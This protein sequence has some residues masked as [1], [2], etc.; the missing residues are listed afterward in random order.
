MG[1]TRT[2]GTNSKTKDNLG[3][4]FTY[5]LGNPQTSVR[6]YSSLY[7]PKYKV[8][9][10]ELHPDHPY[11]GGPFSVESVQTTFQDDGI[12][13]A[14]VFYYHPVLKRW[15]TGEG[16][17]YR[18]SVRAELSTYPTYTTQVGYAASLG[19]EAWNRM[20]P[21][22]KQGFGQTLIEL[23]ELTQ[24][25]FKRVL[26]L[27]NVVAAL[28][29][30]SSNYLAVEFGWKPL[31]RDLFAFEQSISQI[32][33]TLAQLRAKNGK[34]MRRSGTLF[35]ETT[36]SSAS[37][38]LG[39]NPCG[40]YLAS[41]SA[42]N[43]TVVHSRAWFKGVLRYYVP[44]L[45]DP[46]WGGLRGKLIALGLDAS[47]ETIYNLTPWT[48][49]LDWFTNVGSVV[50]NLSRQ[51]TDQIQA[52]YAYVMYNRIERRMRTVTGSIWYIDTYN[53]TRKYATVTP[54][55]ECVLESK[56]RCEADPYRF[57]VKPFELTAWQASILGALGLSRLRLPKPSYEK[58]FL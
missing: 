19:A 43:R 45:E 21:I 1:R 36:E 38:Q 39:I 57:S 26:G 41:H 16:Y 58:F 4:Y 40:E 51:I 12:S 29:N 8:C 9:N 27:R 48:W 34:Y 47:P 37:D 11:S 54:S 13:L 42:T 25:G 31:L 5:Y 28:K 56:V 3:E 6:A 50:S 32:D 52:K 49:L 23:R 2:E 24:L 44:E 33:Q 55:S 46:R 7:Y 53:G 20:I 18:G 35:D 15:M 14:G 30:A 10:D 22:Q 17:A